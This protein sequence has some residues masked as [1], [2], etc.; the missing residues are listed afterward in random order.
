MKNKRDRVNLLRSAREGI[1]LV[2]KEKQIPPL[3][4]QIQESQMN[5]PLL[6]PPPKCSKVD[7]LLSF[8]WGGTAVSI[9]NCTDWNET[10]LKTELTRY[11]N[12]TCIKYVEEIF[13]PIKWDTDSSLH[14][15]FATRT[16]SYTDS[17]LHG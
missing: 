6:P 7:P 3:Q 17:S 2:F 15:Q 10:N 13:D 9:N 8:S 12:I 5:E 16:V 1:M 11:A 4:F 14:G